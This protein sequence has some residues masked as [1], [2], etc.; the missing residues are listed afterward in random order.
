MPPLDLPE[1]YNPETAMLQ[2]STEEGVFHETRKAAGLAARLIANGC[3]EDLTTARR[4]LPA[5]LACQEVRSGDP[6]RGNFYW[7]RE[8]EVVADLNAG[9]FVLSALLPTL[10]RHEDRLPEDLRGEIRVRLGIALE[11]VERLDV[12]LRYSNIAL[13]DC[14]CRSLG[15]AYLNDPA[16]SVRGAEKLSRWLELTGAGHPDEF[17]SPT[18]LGVDLRTL[19]TLADFAPDELTRWQ[20][21]TLADRCAVSVMLHQH[22]P[23]G[24]WAG[25]HGRAYRT[26]LERDTTEQNRIADLRREDRLPEWANHVR[27]PAEVIETTDQENRRRIYTYQT[28]NLALGSATSAPHDQANAV[29]GHFALRDGSGVMFTRYLTN[30][31]WFGDARHATDRTRQRH[32]PDEGRTL[33]LQDRERILLVASPRGALQGCSHA[34]LSLCW[35][36]DPSE[37]RVWAEGRYRDDLPLALDDACGPIVVEIGALCF[38]IRL[39]ARTSLGTGGLQLRH[40]DGC[41][42]LEV[43]NYRG[44]AKDF[45]ETVQPGFFF[46]GPPVCALY[47]ETVETGQPGAAGEFATA[48]ADGSLECGPLGAGD[49]AFAGGATD[50][51]NGRW[52]LSY[53]RGGRDLRLN[54]HLGEWL[55]LQGQINGQEVDWP[56]LRSDKAGANAQGRIQVGGAEYTGPA[57]PA[58][59]YV[60]ADRAFCVVGYLGRNAAA[61]VLKLPDGATRSFSLGGPA[62]LVFQNGEVKSHGAPVRETDPTQET[63]RVLEW[64]ATAPGQAC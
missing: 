18:Y 39:A 53:R 9:V 58:W 59:M 38:G 63:G 52:S 21:R 20:A 37:V 54:A 10:I 36:C 8:D 45:W 24:R 19:T 5:V 2:H 6:H 46:K 29:C 49:G 34:G 3:A 16:L 51:C 12:E 22:E 25:P 1:N 11:E 33:A 26:S 50:R 56:S 43:A 44:P 30:D 31:K 7:M 61:I 35:T 48:L 28:E 14:L 42:I 4:V 17:N 40:H 64:P 13:L 47:L 60:D 27:A 62:T 23:T 32:L 41:L 55:F 15:G 57:E